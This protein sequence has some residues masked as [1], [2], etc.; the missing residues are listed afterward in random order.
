VSAADYSADYDPDADFDRV[1]TVATA[2]VISEHLEPSSSV[3]DLGCATGLMA[4]EVLAACPEI[5]YMGIDHSDYYLEKARAK[6]L[7]NAEFMKADLN[8]LSVSEKRWDHVLL[9]NIIHEVDQPAVLISQCAGLLAAGG[10]IHLTLQNPASV[11]RLTALDLGLIPTLDTISVRGERFATK[12]MMFQ[13]ELEGLVAGAGFKVEESSG[14]FLKPF[15]NE[16]LELLEQ[17]MLSALELA[18]RHFPKH[19]AMNYVRGSI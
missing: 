5:A 6:N 18:G 4:E 16:M 8:Q 10:Q 17:D 15:P 3:L 1:F 13:A 19:S 11:H 7:T 9:T 2:K 12:R 14:I